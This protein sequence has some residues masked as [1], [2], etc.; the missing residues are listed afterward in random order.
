[1]G[2]RSW[3]TRALFALWV[4]CLAFVGGLPLAP[5]ATAQAAGSG[6]ISGTVTDNSGN[7]LA[8]IE[9]G[10]QG[11]NDGWYEGVTDENGDYELTDL[12]DQ[13]Y[14][15]S[16]VDP[17]GLH[18]GE[19]H[20]STT[21]WNAA[22]WL[23]VT[24]GAAVSGI[25]AT[26]EPGGWITGSILDET[27]NPFDRTSICVVGTTSRCEDGSADGTY[28]VGGLATGDYYI[29]VEA[30]ESDGTFRSLW[31]DG[32]HGPTGA[33]RVPVVLGQVS[34]GIDFTFDRTLYG[35][36]SGTVLDENGDPFADGSV[37]AEGP[38]D[39]CDDL[40][41]DGTYTLGLLPGEY[42]IS[43]SVESGQLR[44]YYDGT[45]GGTDEWDEALPVAVVAGA[46]VSGVDTVFDRSRFGTISGTV[47]QPD[48]TPF[49][50][51]W[52]CVEGGPSW[53]C[54]NVNADGTY[55]LRFLEPGEYLVYF[56]AAGE[57]DPEGIIEYYDGADGPERATP[58]TVVGGQ[59][60]TGI[61]ARY[62]SG[63]PG[64]GWISGT[65]VF[66]SGD[67]VTSGEVCAWPRGENYPSMCVEMEADGSFVLGPLA[68]DFYRIGAL[69][70][71]DDALADPMH[72]GEIHIPFDG[73]TVTDVE[74]VFAPAGSV[75]G[76]VTGPGGTPVAGVAV[77]LFG[78]DDSWLPSYVAETR[79]DGGYWIADVPRQDYRVVFLPAD[80]SGLAM[81]WH[82]SPDGSTARVEVRHGAHSVVS[83][84]LVP[85]GSVGGSVT[86]PAGNPVAGVEVRLRE[87]GSPWVSATAIS[88]PDG[89][90]SIASV[91]P[92]DYQLRFVAPEGSS[93]S[94]V[95]YD[96]T[97][98]R[99][100]AGVVQVVPG[101]S[102][103]A[104]ATMPW[105]SALSG[106]VSGPGGTPV[107][108]AV[109]RAYRATDGIVPSG[110]TETAADGSYSLPSL[111]RG[112]Y[113]LHVT[114][115]AGSG[116]VAGWVDGATRSTARL[117]VIDDGYVVADVEL[118]TG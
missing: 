23:P 4:S 109:V 45:A 85:V 7:P 28:A 51:A 74:I 81:T 2:T 48:G 100:E 79:A 36:I 97:I 15:I 114:A 92:G 53:A 38:I 69:F 64:E 44:Q 113:R 83:Q 68:P 47:L 93:V 33:T 108:G 104:D 42:R 112:E 22:T 75:S 101:S 91:D 25:D 40:A 65:T 49:V 5:Q 82:T 1:M 98:L 61:D 62:D 70:D 63:E 8:G 89:S 52:A 60:V 110:R 37:C 29:A 30:W 115:P 27:G 39:E 11:W 58:I 77:G 55:E 71:F 3:S 43:F 103:T 16:Y 34:G 31:Y 105:S 118:T 102:L 90:Y 117:I 17:T 19:Y 66:A 57:G 21:D 88:G 46:S 84:R 111:P 35:T 96:G 87:P 99:A 10:A 14:V 78:P 67:P 73:E 94:D 116:L 106:T 59:T 72:D 9:V 26:L 13:N 6:S 56:G 41:A 20:D 18:A 50:Y 80:G 76:L 24:D 107:G 54:T 86:D 32:V 95:W 12:S